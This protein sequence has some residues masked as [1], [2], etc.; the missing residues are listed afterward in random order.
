MFS[1][2]KRAGKRLTRRLLNAKL[3]SSTEHLD[4]SLDIHCEG[5]K[6]PEEG[7]RGYADIVN[8]DMIEIY[9]ERFLALHFCSTN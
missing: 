3:N 8:S 2:G 5:R 1:N 6:T 9:T 4:P 7:I